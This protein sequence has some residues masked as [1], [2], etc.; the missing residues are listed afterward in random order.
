MNISISIPGRFGNELQWVAKAHEAA[1]GQ[2]FYGYVSVTINSYVKPNKRGEVVTN[3]FSDAK[4]IMNAL[5]GILWEKGAHLYRVQINKF[6]AS[7]ECIEV[8]VEDI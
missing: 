1:R 4:H 8:H 3:V 7:T 6:S 2:K 5:Q